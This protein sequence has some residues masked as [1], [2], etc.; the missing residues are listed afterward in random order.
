MMTTSKM[1]VT[2]EFDRSD[3]KLNIDELLEVIARDCI[4]S[5]HV[6]DEDFTAEQYKKYK[7]LTP[8]G[9]FWGGYAYLY[10]I[11][12]KTYG[13][14]HLYMQDGGSAKWCFWQE[15]EKLMFDCA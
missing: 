6:K 7:Q 10:T 14:L 8:P 13:S 9:E 11:D 15:G 4:E 12:G 2:Q 3:G 5:N 1:S